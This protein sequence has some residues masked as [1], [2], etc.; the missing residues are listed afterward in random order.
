[1]STLEEQS[2]L[3]DADADAD[4]DPFTT[5]LPDFSVQDFWTDSTKVSSYSRGFGNV[6]K[7]KSRWPVL[8]FL[9]GYPQ[10]YVDRYNSL[11]HAS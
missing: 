2:N 4:A 11:T 8:V 7:D 5:L 10:S 1:M 9:H 6:E 3:R